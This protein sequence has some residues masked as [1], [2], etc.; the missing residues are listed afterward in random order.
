MDIS[1]VPV[2]EIP[3][4]MKTSRY[5]DIRK[6]LLEIGFNHAVKISIDP[7]AEPAAF[8]QYVSAALHH[9]IKKLKLPFAISIRKRDKYLYVLKIDSHENE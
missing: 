4:V 2:S 7:D 5:G 6:A 1:I 8:S 9:C 3:V